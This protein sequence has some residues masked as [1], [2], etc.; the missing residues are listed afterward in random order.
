MVEKFSTVLEKLP[1]VLRGD[2][3]DSHCTFE[4]HAQYVKDDVNLTIFG[5]IGPYDSVMHKRATL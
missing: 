3:L 5:C 2:F 1:Q 4:F